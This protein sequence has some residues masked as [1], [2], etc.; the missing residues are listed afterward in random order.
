[1]WPVIQKPYF[2]GP[3]CLKMVL[4]HYGIKSP[5]QGELAKLCRSK[6]YRHANTGTAGKNIL[7]AGKSFGLDGF[8]QDMSTFG[9]LRGWVEK[10]K[11]PVI[12]SWFAFDEG[13]Y[14]VAVKVTTRKIYLQDPELGHI[15]VMDK[16]KFLR[17]WFDYSGAFIR[18]K[19][20][21]HV[22]RMIVLYPKKK[23]S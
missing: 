7:A 10:K 19:K 23:K 2:C 16:P 3:A 1:M 22:R 20:D 15:R 6:A 21:V 5:R 18:E 13:H 12:V 4:R 11:V 8:L 17:L 9:E 14:S